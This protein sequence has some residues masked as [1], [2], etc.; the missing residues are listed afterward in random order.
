MSYVC[1][2]SNNAFHL[3]SDAS[4]GYPGGPLLFKNL[5][6]GID[7]DS[8]IASMIFFPLIFSWL[9]Q[10]ALLIFP[11]VIGL[12]FQW[13]VLMALASRLYWN[14][15]PEICNLLLGQCS[16]PQGALFFYL[17]LALQD[18][19]YFFFHAS[20]TSPEQIMNNLPLVFLFPCSLLHPLFVYWFFSFCCL[21]GPYGCIQ[22]TSCWWAWLNSESPFVHDEVLSGKLKKFIFVLGRLWS[23]SLLFL[24]S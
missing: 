2:L 23:P 17:T 9:E 19:T 8:R 16:A 11:S 13:L 15:Y 14:W 18:W 12:F 10:C 21:T 20:I 7:L 24:F 4:F 5:N 22:S 1:P 6:F 3:C